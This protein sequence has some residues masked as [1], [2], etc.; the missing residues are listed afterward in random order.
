MAPGAGLN[1]RRFGRTGSGMKIRFGAALV[2]G[3]LLGGVSGLA[4]G[5]SG[6]GS[7]NW[8]PAGGG[9]YG[10][11]YGAVTVAR[12]NVAPVAGAW[13]GGGGA[14]GVGNPAG[15]ATGGS[16]GLFGVTRPTPMAEANVVAAQ[17]FG[18]A[19]VP[20]ATPVGAYP[21]ATPRGVTYWG[22]RGQP[23]NPG[24]RIA[25]PNARPPSPTAPR[26]APQAAPSDLPA[27]APPFAP[28]VQLATAQTKQAGS[29]SV[30]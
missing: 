16:G 22:W 29:V 14:A 2:A 19:G 23:G 13:A 25:R 11:G 24:S 18:S 6:A 28:Q 9:G 26:T 1:I 5:F 21:V 7:G 15:P 30:R 12:V 3:W 20:L 10:G 27:E 4:Q 17:F 8:G